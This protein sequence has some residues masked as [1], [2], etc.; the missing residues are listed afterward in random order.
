MVLVADNSLPHLETE[1]DIETALAEWFRCARSGGGCLISM[2]DY[3]SPP[4]AGTLEV[5][6]YGD[7]VWEGRRYRLRQAWRWHGPRYELTLE[8]SAADDVAAEPVAILRTSYQCITP[9]RVA[10]LMCAV[11]FANVQRVDGRFFQPVL[12]GTRP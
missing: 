1:R 7:R 10:D 9:A 6:P 5:H 4:P 3:G 8:I 12:V 2:R 11:G